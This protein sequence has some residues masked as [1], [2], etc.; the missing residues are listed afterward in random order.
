[1][2]KYQII[3]A[4]PPWEGSSECIAKKSHINFKNSFHYPP[5]KLK[6]IKNLPVKNIVDENCLLFL[7]TRSPILDWALEVGKH[8]GFEYITIA[9]VWDKQYILPGNYTLSQIEICLLFKKGKIPLPRGKRNVKQFLSEK[10]RKH[11]QKPDTIRNRI[12]EMFPTQNKIE[13]FARKPKDVLFK[14]ESFKGWHV[15]GDEVKSDIK[16]EVVKK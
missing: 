14:N 3:Y 1:M 5:M 15:W 11:S 12:T 2:K 16:M 13:L 9:F 7:W 4:D 6:D 10:R 8:W